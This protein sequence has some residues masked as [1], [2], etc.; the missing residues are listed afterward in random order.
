MGVEACEASHR[1]PVDD[2]VLPFRVVSQE[3]R[4][5]VLYRV[6]GVRMY[7]RLLVRSLHANVECRGEVAADFV[8]A[9]F[10]HA[11]DYLGV[12]DLEGSDQCRIVLCH[13]L[14]PWN[15]GPS[16]AATTRLMVKTLYQS[17]RD[18]VNRLTHR[19]HFLVY[20]S[21]W[22][23]QD[24]TLWPAWSLLPRFRPFEAGIFSRP[25]RRDG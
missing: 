5:Y 3:R 6:H 23:P 14:S 18:V 4:H 19:R 12:I 11:R 25:Q 2:P 7:G 22:K 1:S 8:P 20:Y 15:K 9:R 10:V 24:V 13:L 21:P 16:P 17:R